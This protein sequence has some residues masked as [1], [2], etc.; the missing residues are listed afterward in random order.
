MTTSDY[1]ALLDSAFEK[2]PERSGSSERFEAPVAKSFVQGNKT[3]VDNFDFVCQR[4]RREPKQI[5]KY[6]FNELGVPGSIGGKT[7]VLQG[8]FHNRIINEK[9]QAYVK[10][11]V[12]CSECNR[13][14]T[15]VEEQGR[16]VLLL[17]CE[18]CGARK[19]LRI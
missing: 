11:C 10:H 19:P 9:L 18:A 17:V 2:I 6:L 5:A 12:F 13:P 16:G 7:L 4:L 14:D 8:K 3:M 1:E 15:R